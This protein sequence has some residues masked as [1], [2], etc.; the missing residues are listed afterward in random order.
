MPKPLAFSD[1]AKYQKAV[2][3]TLDELERNNVISRIWEHDHKVWKDNPAE[4]TN[5]LGWLHSPEGFIN[6]VDDIN[7]FVDEIKAEGYTNALLLGMGGSS[8]APEV[9]RQ[10]FGVKDGYLDLTVLDST[11]PGAVLA[12]GGRIDPSKTLFIA[13]TKSGTTV[14]TLSLLKYF[15]NRVVNTLGEEKAGKN[16]IAITD[17]GSALE[18]LGERLKFKA[19]FFNDT[20]IGGR[21]SALSCFGII[22]AALIGTDIRELL[23]RGIG[24]AGNCR[25]VGGLSEGLNLGALLGVIIGKM[26]LMGRDKL[27]LVLSPRIA[28]FGLWLEQLIAESLGK[29][30]KGILPVTGEFLAD[31][32]SYTADRHFVQINVEGDS[33]SNSEIQK[34]VDAGI[35]VTRLYLK[36]VYDLSGAMFQWEFATAVAG[37]LLKV[38]PFDQPN[39]ESSKAVARKMVE[40]YKEKGKLPQPKPSLVK[41]GISAYTDISA[42]SHG[43]ILKRFLSKTDPGDEDGVGR[44]Y[45]A[46]QA[47]IRQ[48]DETDNAIAG[49][50]KKIQL[51]RKMAT[52]LGYG[53]RYLHS[54]GQLH[55]GDAG[56]G[57]FIQLTADDAEDAPIPDEAGSKSSSISFGILKAAQALGDRQALVDNSRKVIRFHLGS[58]I[59][60]GIKRLAEEPG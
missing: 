45:I 59:I 10:S 16:F 25:F 53:P 33:D 28:S 8:L 60:G 34:L 21:Y 36:D 27:T 6:T 37:Y 31:P 3:E 55:K 1:S 35:P 49:L 19:A 38:N 5:R 50:R 18:E 22:P 29:E 47:F 44:S 30:G 20:H 9:F 12:Q 17:P 2:L 51:G 26:A 7:Q 15:Y 43:E 40:T 41:D 39:V 23:E 14:E 46:I 56:H 54:T 24:M 4:I 32:G 52:T 13:S 58:D 48:T 57:R 11:D 42:E